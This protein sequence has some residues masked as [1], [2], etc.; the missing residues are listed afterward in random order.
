MAETESNEPEKLDP[1]EAMRQALERKKQAEHMSA[2]HGITADRE[3]GHIHGKAAG[4]RE[5]RR[6]SG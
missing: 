6:K 4:K 1:K 2:S 5:F 3:A